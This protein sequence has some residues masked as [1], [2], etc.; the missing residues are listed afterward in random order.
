L[1]QWYYGNNPFYLSGYGLP[2]CTCY[3]YGRAGEI[4]NQFLPL[5]TGNAGNWY[6]NTTM[7]K[8]NTPALGAT[9]V[10]QSRSGRWAGHVATVEQIFTDGSVLFSCSGYNRPIYSYPPDTPSYF[11]TERCYPSSNMLM[12]YMLSRDYF[13][14][15]YIYNPFAGDLS[16][17]LPDWIKG[18]RLLTHPEMESN[19]IRVWSILY[20]KGWTRNAVAGLLGNMQGE[21]TIN[22]GIWENLTPDI[23]RGW[24]LVQWTPSTNFTDWAHQHGYDND[25]GDAQLE[26]IDTET[27]PFGQWAPTTQYPM[28]FDEFKV[29]AIDPKELASA[30]LRDFERPGDIPGTEPI[31]REN[32]QRWFDYLAN[33][34]PMLPGRIED[35]NRKMPLWMMLK[36]W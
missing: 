1:S 28:S 2:N 32:A 36:Y 26:W 3:A 24:G 27:V 20:F 11:W 14:K 29:S 13:L 12:N 35:R 31:R 4:A 15:G 10:W 34:D 25:D 17:V 33:I 8:G 6:D 30:F 22:P 5:P 18:N 23:S 19:A 16:S 21:S 9:A 7:A